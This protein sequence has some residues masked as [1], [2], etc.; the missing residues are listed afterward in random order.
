MIRHTA[1]LILAAT[2]LVHAQRN[3]C[4]ETGLVY[5]LRWPERQPPVSIY[6]PYDVLLGYIA[7]DSIIN[8]ATTYNET[9]G[10]VQQVRSFLERRTSFDDTLKKDRPLPLRNGGLRPDALRGNPAFLPMA[11]TPSPHDLRGGLSK[12]SLVRGQMTSVHSTAT[13]SCSRQT[14]SPT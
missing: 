11:S 9:W 13:W 5:Q 4:G 7:L 12:R 8:W 1:L 2:V 10:R 14:T 3:P 6:M